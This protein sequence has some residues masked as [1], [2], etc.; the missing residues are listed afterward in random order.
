PVPTPTISGGSEN[1]S[2]AAVKAPR[3]GPTPSG[4]VAKRRS[5]A[6]KRALTTFIN[7]DPANFRQ[8]VQQVT[9]AGF[10][11][12]QFATAQLLKPEPLRLRHVVPAMDSSSFFC[13]GAAAVMAATGTADGGAGTA[14][15]FDS[16]CSFPTLESWKVM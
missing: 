16:F 1:E 4:R 9:G 7:A 15:D 10:P 5:R 3:A 8:M 11:A 13:D 14:L 6:S 12:G 2:T